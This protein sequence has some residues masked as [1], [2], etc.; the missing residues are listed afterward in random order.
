MLRMLRILGIVV[1][2]S[3]IGFSANSLRKMHESGELLDKYNSQRKADITL[4][5]VSFLAISALGYFEVSRV[6][7]LGQWHG[8]RHSRSV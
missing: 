6:R 2:A 4:L 5:G 8:F 1:F 3:M 7:R